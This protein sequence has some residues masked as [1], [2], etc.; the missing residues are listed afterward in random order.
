[1]GCLSIVF[2][3][4]LVL[5]EIAIYVSGKR[6]IFESVSLWLIGWQR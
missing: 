1:M 3:H 4:G 5:A 2:L 6:T